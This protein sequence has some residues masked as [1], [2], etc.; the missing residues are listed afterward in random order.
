M[1]FRIHIDILQALTEMNVTL[2]LLV[3]L[4]SILS[5][6]YSL[7]LKKGIAIFTSSLLLS[8]NIVLA[9]PEGVNRPDLLPTGE[10]TSLID[11]ANYLSK[12]QEKKVKG[13]NYN[14]LIMFIILIIINNK[15][16]LMN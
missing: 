5:N 2:L 15:H 9:R 14:I 8:S 12:G 13:I 6:V 1:V 7:K 11:V 3:L 10:K 16:Q 4:L